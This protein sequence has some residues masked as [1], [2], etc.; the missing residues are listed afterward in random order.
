VLGFA[1]WPAAASAQGPGAAPS[2]RL[3]AADSSIETTRNTVLCCPDFGLWVT[4]AGGDFRIDLTR[5]GYGPWEASQVDPD[6][7]TVLRAI[8]RE[9][10]AGLRGLRDFLTIRVVNA[11]GRTA[12]RRRVTFCPG[13]SD[14]TERFHDEGPVLP[15]YFGSCSRGFPFTRGMVWGLTD[16]WATPIAV[17]GND[18][19]RVPRRILRRLPQRIRERLRRQARRAPAP[20]DLRPGRYRVVARI[21]ERYRSLFAIPADQASVSVRM[22][23]ARPGRLRRPG[24]AATTRRKRAARPLAAQTVQQPSPDTVPDLAALPPWDVQ[25]TRGRRGRA[26]GHDYLRFAGS[27]WNA[28]PAPLVVEGFRLPGED[29]MAAYQYFFDADGDV[30]GRAPA[31]GMVFHDAPSHNHWHFLQLV[32]YRIVRADGRAVVRARKQAFCITSTDPV[33]LTVPGAA[34]LGLD[35]FSGSSCGSTGSIWLRQALPAG[36]AD[37]YGA[38][39]PGQSFDITG[40]PNGRYLVE[41]EVNPGGDLYEVTTDNNVARRRIVLSGRRGARRVRVAPWNGIRR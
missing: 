9:S 32:T 16:G 26:R 13:G 3:V 14:V 1:L 34:D 27:P 4:P 11:R 2:L 40:V 37:T 24:A 29:V 15:G 39:L 18:I 41:M 28:G 19:G 35:T 5:P 7:G 23:V 10:I 20:F 21:A 12:V 38:G 17:R 33:D 8:P 22:R 6:D 25:T 30:V 36:W 31:G